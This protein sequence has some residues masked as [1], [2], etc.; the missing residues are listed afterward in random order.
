[1]SFQPLNFKAPMYSLCTV[2]VEAAA[3]CTIAAVTGFNIPVATTLYATTRLVNELVVR[4]I[5][6]F[7][8]K[9]LADTDRIAPAIMARTVVVLTATS[10]ALRVIAQAALPRSASFALTCLAADKI[11]LTL[12]AAALI[13]FVTLGV[14]GICRNFSVFSIDKLT[15]LAKNTAKTSSEAATSVV[16]GLHSAG[17]NGLTSVQ[18]GSIKAY[19]LA[20]QGGAKLLNAGASVASH[21]IPKVEHA[22]AVAAEAVAN[23][24]VKVAL[25]A[26]EAHDKLEQRAEADEAK[27]NEAAPLIPNASSSNAN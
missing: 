2:A 3:T 13:F 5:G 6:L 24:G 14:S 16:S 8:S 21:L 9:T 15:D 10:L 4:L 20:K 18:D 1:V 27:A 26:A 12:A 17:S 22:A 25:G 7:N 19:E 11:A 23:V